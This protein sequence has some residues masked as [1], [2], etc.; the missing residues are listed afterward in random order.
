VTAPDPAAQQALTAAL[1]TL[2]GLSAEAPQ[3]RQLAR[4]VARLLP[5]LVRVPPGANGVVIATVREGEITEAR[6]YLRG[7]AEE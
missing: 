5:Q 1:A 4:W 2:T 6:P 7:W 3:A